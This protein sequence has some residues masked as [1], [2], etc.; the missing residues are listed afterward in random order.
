MGP[1]YSGRSGE[2]CRTR[3]CDPIRRCRSARGTYWPNRASDKKSIGNSVPPS[4]ANSASALPSTGA[5]LKSVAGKA[6]GEHHVWR[7]AGADRR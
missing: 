6:R 7:A 3:Y 2:P 4:S 1:I 5:N